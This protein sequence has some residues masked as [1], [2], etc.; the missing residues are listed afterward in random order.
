[1][2]DGVWIIHCTYIVRIRKS[3]DDPGQRRPG[4][5][6]N[7]PSSIKERRAQI[8]F[9]LGFYCAARGPLSLWSLARPFLLSPPSSTM[10]FEGLFC[11]S[12]PGLRDYLGCRKKHTTRCTCSTHANKNVRPT[13]GE[14]KIGISKSQYARTM[15]EYVRTHDTKNSI[16]VIYSFVF[17]F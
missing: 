2:Q 10:V 1:M 17:Q 4:A 15:S 11:C 16:E 5:P 9:G 7:A 8:T 12:S 13:K 6:S 14:K 3:T